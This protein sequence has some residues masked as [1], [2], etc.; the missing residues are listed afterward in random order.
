MDIEFIDKP[1][2]D[3]LVPNTVSCHDK[4]IFLKFILVD[5]ELDDMERDFLDDV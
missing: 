2:W 1:R 5:V 3:N 4:L